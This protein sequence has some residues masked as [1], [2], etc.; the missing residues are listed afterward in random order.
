MTIPRAFSDAAEAARYQAVMSPV[1]FMQVEARSETITMRNGLDW[2]TDLTTYSRKINFPV[3]EGSATP[4]WTVEGKERQRDQAGDAANQG[5]GDS[6]AAVT[7][8]YTV[9]RKLKCAIER[10]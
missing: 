2:T 9:D 3:G 10:V 6:L 7:L 1:G 8:K 5:S 4:N